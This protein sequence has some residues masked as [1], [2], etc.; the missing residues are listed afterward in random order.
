MCI[1]EPCVFVCVSDVMPRALRRT[2][3]VQSS[4]RASQEALYLLLVTLL[5]VIIVCSR[6]LCHESPVEKKSLKPVYGISSFFL[7]CIFVEISGCLLR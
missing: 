5:D 2:L 3:C 1:S 4:W 7:V 6:Q